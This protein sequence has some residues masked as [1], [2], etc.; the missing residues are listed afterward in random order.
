MNQVHQWLK[1]LNI[2]IT[3]TVL[4][5]FLLLILGFISS[6]IYARFLG[7]EGR[8]AIFL[9]LTV[10]SMIVQFG[11]LGLHTSNTYLVARDKSLL[12]GL[13]ANSIWVSIFITSLSMATV[14]II[15][16]THLLPGIPAAYLWFAAAFAAP[17][18]FYMFGANLL[19]GINRI[20]TF[21]LLEIG[22]RF[23]NFVFI[24]IAILLSLNVNGFL[25]FGLGANILVSILVLLL[26]R[27]KSGDSLK[28]RPT[29]FKS[30]FR[31]ALKAYFTGLLSFLVMRGNVYLLQWYGGLKQLGYVSV[32][33]NLVDMMVILPT[34][35]SLIV[36]PNLIRKQEEKWN[37]TLKNTVMVG[38]LTLI[39]CLILV[40]IAK[41]F[42]TI[43]F[44]AEFVPAFPILIRM[45]PGIFFLSMI[46]VL[47]QYLAASGFPP[48]VIGS[49]LLV[50]VIV[51]VV[52]WFLI[53]KMAGIGVAIA[54]STGYTLLFILIFG[55]AW[56]IKRQSSL[57]TM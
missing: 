35:V 10:A 28:F 3:I 49:W 31:Y 23:V 38:I 4:S 36:F 47:S 16:K 26:L 8:G 20:R 45:L 9:V 41:P 54:F 6:I 11:S 1:V 48:L 13:L 44:G 5:R 43:I 34:S 2:D 42:I 52:G 46:T 19:V 15:Q 56:F 18:L 40:V 37:I 21:N 24:V 25:W 57:K 27:Y 32:C 55:L 53:P 33:Y 51:L 39:A 50:L 17:M 29:L 22:N 12:G 30:G 14:L 7:P